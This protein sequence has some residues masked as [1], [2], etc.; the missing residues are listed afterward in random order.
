M[1]SRHNM[2]V[3]TMALNMSNKIFIK[4]NCWVINR[5]LWKPQ[6]HAV[7]KRNGF[8]NFRCR[9][10]SVAGTKIP[11]MN[12]SKER[13][14]NF[15]SRPQRNQSWLGPVSLRALMAQCIMLLWQH[16]VEKVNVH[17][18]VK[19]REERTEPGSNSRGEGGHQ[20]LHF[21]Q[22][23]PTSKASAISP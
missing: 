13:N 18:T 10:V 12:N 2:S 16:M 14:I 19:L 15:G 11:E 7:Y 6:L 23:I 17:L 20:W 9:P 5:C 1:N 8:Q 21:L 3:P 22:L 4:L